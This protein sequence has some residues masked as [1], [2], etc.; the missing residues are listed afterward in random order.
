[1]AIE[2]STINA[3]CTDARVYS[4]QVVELGAWSAMDFLVTLR[5]QF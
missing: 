2:P 4:D 5:L 1:M 3:E